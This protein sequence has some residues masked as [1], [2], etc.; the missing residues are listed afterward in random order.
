MYLTKVLYSGQH[1]LF[2]DRSFN[3][4]LFCLLSHMEMTR[5]I[6]VDS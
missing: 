2:I 4:H 3:T 6:V 5:M 1:I